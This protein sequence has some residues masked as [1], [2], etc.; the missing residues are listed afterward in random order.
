MRR[1]DEDCRL[2]FFSEGREQSTLFAGEDRL[3]QLRRLWQEAGNALEV[4]LKSPNVQG[5]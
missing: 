5:G 1:Q 4:A 2:A 3:A